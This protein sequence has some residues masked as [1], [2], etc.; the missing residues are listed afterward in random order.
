MYLAKNRQSFF[1]QQV[2]YLEQQIMYTTQQCKYEEEYYFYQTYLREQQLRQMYYPQ[3][4][5]V[6]PVANL[7][8]NP[9][10]QQYAYH[11][12][13]GVANIGRVRTVKKYMPPM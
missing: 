13:I 3:Q 4:I 9:V 6:F 11:Q 5:N 10:E 12:N 8:A 7:A 2:T 1:T